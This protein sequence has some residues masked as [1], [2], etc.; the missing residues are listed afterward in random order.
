MNPSEFMSN[1]TYHHKRCVKK[2]NGKADLAARGNQGWVVLK[3]PIETRTF[4][5]QELVTIVGNVMVSDLWLNYEIIP[6]RWVTND[7]IAV[8]WRGRGENIYI[9]TIT[10]RFCRSGCRTTI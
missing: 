7:L 1:W 3:P 2:A 8:D 5:S 10:K 9:A 4:I 6:N